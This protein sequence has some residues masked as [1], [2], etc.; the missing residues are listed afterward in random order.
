[1]RFLWNILIN[2]THHI[3]V[4]WKS[5][6]LKFS[7]H[8][9]KKEKSR[10]VPE[11]EKREELKFKKRTELKEGTKIRSFCINI[12]HLSAFL[13][14]TPA[15]YLLGDPILFSGNTLLFQ[16]TQKLLPAC[17]QLSQLVSLC[18]HSSCLIC[19]T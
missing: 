15:L 16:K 13:P 17:L 6:Q 12:T 11:E 10:G 3:F 2:P 4:F 7:S 8:L 19:H 1:M 9:K 5:H 18:L 14:T